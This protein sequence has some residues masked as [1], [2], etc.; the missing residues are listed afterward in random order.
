MSASEAV[1][2]TQ[3][4]HGSNH[5]FKPGEQVDP[6]PDRLYGGEDKAYASPRIEAAGNF[7]HGSVNRGGRDGR[8]SKPVQGALFAPVYEVEPIEPRDSMTGSDSVVSHKGLKVKR[9]AAYSRTDN[10]ADDASYQKR[11]FL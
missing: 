8:K 11:E 2:P 10:L 5:W 4:F 7:A 6:T 1:S 3:F 9:L